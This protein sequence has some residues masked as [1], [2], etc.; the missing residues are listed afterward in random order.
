MQLV[1]TKAFISF[2]VLD[3]APKNDCSTK[4]IPHINLKST[5]SEIKT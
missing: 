5:H 1:I 3:E 2:H 4:T